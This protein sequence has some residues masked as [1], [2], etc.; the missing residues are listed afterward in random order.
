M[1]STN[2]FPVKVWSSVLCVFLLFSCSDFLE[3]NPKNQVGTSNYY[4]TEQ[5][6]LAAVNSIYA[7]LGSYDASRGNTAG[8]YHST[9]WVT[10][11]LASDEMDN[12]QLGAPQ[13]DQLATFTHNADNA[14]LQEIWQVHYKTIY[15]ANVAID[16]I[17][18]IEMDE[19][20]KN[21]FIN[22]AKFL[23]GL[24]YFNLVRMFGDIPLVI[25]EETPLNP[26]AA[27][28]DEVYARIIQDLTDAEALPPDGEIQEGRATQGA[29]QA[30]LAK[31]YVRTGE[32][33]LASEKALDV[34]DSG[35]YGLWDRFKDA[36]RIENRGGKEAVFSVGF[37]DAGGAISF[38]E[39]GQF[40]VRL[41]P[42]ALSA[43]VDG[44]S[45]TQGWQIAN[46]NMY[47]TFAT[48]DERRE[49]TF[50]TSFTAS[51]NSTVN[52]DHVYIDKYWDVDADPTAG[53]SF[54]DFPVIR[55]SDVVLTYA[56]AQARLGNFDVANDYLNDIRQRAD[57]GEAEADNIEGFVD[58]LVEERGKEFTGE[59]QRWFD[60]TRLGRLRQRVEAVKGISVGEQ[61]NRFPIPQRERLVNPNLPQNPGF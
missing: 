4:T 36:F 2:N 3:E 40:N 16:R 13:Y 23:R 5:D 57:L 15:L 50:M 6:A 42:A 21:R 20:L 1:K 7:N 58:L 33:Q 52:L 59:G 26:E 27:P 17:P 12:N 55:Y 30:L 44:I 41:L 53:G 51:D 32:Y 29:A 24:L 48:S 54:N 38:W 14:A 60:L 46:A 45:N 61:Y 10:Q 56:E 37:G 18:A 19:T 47:N 25:T 8:I 43:E 9:F 11:G 31:V 39:V 22:E 49:D 28:A 35:L 34:M